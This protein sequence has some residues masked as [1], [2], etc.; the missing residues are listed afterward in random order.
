MF[1]V[2]DLEGAHGT[3]AAALGTPRCDTADP[4]PG[5]P[6]AAP[7][8]APFVNTQEKNVH[9]PP[10]MDQQDVNVAQGD[11]PGTPPDPSGPDVDGSENTSF[12]RGIGLG[13][14]RLPHARGPSAGRRTPPP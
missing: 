2:G 11:G 12:R 6:A 1:F 5:T 3:G 9:T 7:S 10:T 4:A 13:G 14:R 8:I